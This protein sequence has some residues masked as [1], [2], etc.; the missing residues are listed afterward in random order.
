[1]SKRKD[2]GLQQ[3]SRFG[4]LLI[5]LVIII[6]D[7]VTKG[8]VRQELQLYEQRP[9]I[10]FWDWTLAYNRGAAF[11][12]FADQGG[13]QRIFFGVLATVV[14][15]GLVYYLLNKVY[16]RLTGVGLCF[17]LGGALG[18]LIDRIMFGKVTD[19]IDWHYNIHHWP[20]FNVADSFITVGV[21]LLIIESIF[22][23]RSKN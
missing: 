6:L 11:S 19:F 17:I 9:F 16:S 8:I 21:T 13:W 12:L 22:F 4:L 1:M 14:A 2:D 10:K 23:D 7:Q 20:A 15:V 18:N 5:S 3:S